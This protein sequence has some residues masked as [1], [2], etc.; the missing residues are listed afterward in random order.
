MLQNVFSAK[1]DTTDT[2]YSFVK[3]YLT[4]ETAESLAIFQAPPTNLIK[5]GLTLI[6]AGLSSTT[7]LHAGG[8]VVLKSDL[9]VEA[10]P[11][12][13]TSQ[14]EDVLNVTHETLVKQKEEIVSVPQQRD[15]SRNETSSKSGKTVP[16]WFK[17]K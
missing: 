13:A 3:S 7:L 10:D 12:R 15:S 2:L 9:D 17:M 16:K 4:E 6:E 1:V 14:L 8:S 11:N 5:Q